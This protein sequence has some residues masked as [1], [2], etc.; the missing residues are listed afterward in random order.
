MH[1]MKRLGFR[2]AGSGT[3]L[4][5]PMRLARHGKERQV[6]GMDDLIRRRE[7]I[8]ALGE[9][10]LVWVG[11]DYELGVRNQYDCDRLAVETAP[12]VDAV[13]VVRCGECRYWDRSPSCS[14][15]PQYHACKRRI[16]A[17]VHTTRDD[18]CSQG[19]RKD[20]EQE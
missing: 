18:F 16:F 1:G 9:R 17:D 15:T 11:S 12:T 8:A 2:F 13:P 5:F 4:H 20:G 3:A 7:V 10:P 14:A 6:N 19:A